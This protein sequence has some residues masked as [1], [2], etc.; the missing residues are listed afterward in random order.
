MKGLGTLFKEDPYLRDPNNAN[1]QL[2]RE[3]V[4]QSGHISRL[5]SPALQTFSVQ[6]PY[7]EGITFAG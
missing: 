4:P 5:R 3:F 1:A 7:E 6:H 2:C